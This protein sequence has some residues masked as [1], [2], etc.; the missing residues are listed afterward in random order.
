MAKNL[1][2]GRFKYIGFC[3]VVKLALIPNVQKS[4]VY[5]QLPALALVH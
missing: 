2:G 3:S 4:V 1:L 5:P